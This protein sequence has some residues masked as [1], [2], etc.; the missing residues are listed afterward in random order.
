[1]ADRLEVHGMKIQPLGCRNELRPFDSPML[2]SPAV[3]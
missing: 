1:V 3:S 2:E